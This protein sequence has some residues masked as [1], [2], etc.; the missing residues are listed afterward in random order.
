MHKHKFVPGEWK[1]KHSRENTALQ[2]LGAK[3]NWSTGVMI[4]SMLGGLRYLN[5]VWKLDQG[6]YER[7]VWTLEC[8]Q[9]DIDGKWYE[10]RDLEKANAHNNGGN[11]AQQR[12]QHQGTTGVA[13]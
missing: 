7:A 4:G 5:R 13:G 6:L 11:N 8:L 12:E 10:A 9:I 3:R 1:S 2:N